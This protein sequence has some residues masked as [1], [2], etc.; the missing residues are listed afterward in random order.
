MTIGDICR[1]LDSQV[2]PA[3]QES[4]DNS[5]IQTG[6][7]K[8]DATS[9]L[10]TIDVNEEVIAEA[11]AKGCNL[12]ISHHPLIFSSLKRITDNSPIERALIAAIKKNVTIYSAHTNLDSVYGGVSF[13]MASKLGL[14]NVEV[15]SP[16]KE[17]LVK[18][19]TFVPESHVDKV[20]E[21]VFE[22]GAGQIGNYDSCGFQ[23]VGEGS[24]RGNDNSNPFAGTRG[25]L[26]VAGEIRFET[27]F[28]AYKTSEVVLA[29]T[30]AHPYEEPAYDLIP[31]LNIWT[32][33]GLGC[34][35][36]LEKEIEGEE[37]LKLVKATFH[38]PYLRYS[39]QV[40]ST[41]HKVALC[42]GAGISLMKEAI[43]SGA[44]TFITGDIKYH[45]FQ[46]AGNNI[47]LIDPGHF[48]TEKYSME[49][50]SDLIIKKFPN[51]ALRFSETIT[52]PINFY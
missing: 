28:P 31:L 24:F 45:Q 23:S 49:I 17:K 3:L 21:A 25:E 52:N 36:T 1:Y 47:L 12:V 29:L 13:M 8:N 37:F 14:A 27:I 43:A 10:L 35:G 40:K 7:Y 30:T 20:K 44:D 16:L 5:G 48:E 19:V 50:I 39:G 4:Y 33:A 42:G 32:R 26:H 34:V 2:P 9:A 18:L 6:S 22:A 15:L 11:V 51:F 46:E 41:I 38:P